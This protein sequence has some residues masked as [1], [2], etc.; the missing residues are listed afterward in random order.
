MQ[1]EFY[2]VKDAVL[3]MDIAGTRD[4]IGT[5]AEISCLMKSGSELENSQNHAGQLLRFI[6]SGDLKSEL[7][8]ELADTGKI[9]FLRTTAGSD[10]VIVP[11]G[12][13]PQTDSFSAIILVDRLLQSW[14]AR[15]RNV[16]EMKPR[17]W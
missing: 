16:V 13:E 8:K 17:S 9:D 12:D 2:S 3:A 7:E 6:D 1:T 15:K 4:K 5:A 11:E 10:Y 14:I